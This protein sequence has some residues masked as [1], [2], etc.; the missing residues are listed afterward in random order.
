[1]QVE[2]SSP[3]RLRNP[4]PIDTDALARGRL[5][6]QQNCLSCHGVAGRGD[7]PLGRSLN[8]RPADLRIHVTQHPEGVIY[9]WIANGVPGTAMPAWKDSIA[10]DDRWRLVAFIKG[11]AEDGPAPAQT[12]A[13]ELRVRPAAAA[14]AGTSATTPVVASRALAHPI[15]AGANATA[16][17][18]DVDGRPVTVQ[19]SPARFTRGQPNTIDV[20]LPADAPPSSLK[21]RLSMADHEMPPDQG[22]AQPLGGGRYRIPPDERFDMGGDWRLDLD[23]DGRTA[24]YWLAVSPGGAEVKFVE[25]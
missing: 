2:A 24:T 6:Y 3:E 1:V 20:S 21:Y 22:A 17:Q 7:G 13:A 11:F 9:D 23:V 4:V 12:A 5:L 8:P 19:I 15:A 18:A 25:P 16:A 14:G 10:A